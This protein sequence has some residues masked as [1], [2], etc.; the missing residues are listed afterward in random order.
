MREGNVFSLSTPVGGGV[1]P[2]HVHGGYPSRVH[3]PHRTWPGVPNGEYPTSSTPPNQTWLGV[4]DGGIPNLWY[5]P[6]DLAQGVPRGTQPWVPHQ[7]SS[8]L[9]L[10]LAGGV[11]NGGVP[12]WGYPTSGNRWSTWYGAVGMPLEFTQ[13]D[14]LV[15]TYVQSRVLKGKIFAKVEM[16]RHHKRQNIFYKNSSFI[17]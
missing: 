8:T 16:F 2:S 3:P 10:D 15:V 7:T 9:Q 11:P 5:P 1:Y 14:F 13:E 17:F 6:S 4:P 12:D